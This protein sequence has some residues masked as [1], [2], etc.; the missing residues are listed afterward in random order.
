MIFLIAL[1]LFEI[2]PKKDVYFILS[3]A[4]EICHS[5]SL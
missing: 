5:A 1:P 2:F 4:G 3:K